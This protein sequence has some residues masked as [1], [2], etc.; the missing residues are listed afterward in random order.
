VATFSALGLQW[1]N[2]VTVSDA[3]LSQYPLGNPMFDVTADGLLVRG[4]GPAV[5]VLQ[6]GQLRHVTSPEAMSA[7]FFSFGSVSAYSDGVLDSLAEGPPLSGAPCPRF[8]PRDGTLL[9]GSGAAVYVV[10]G[11]IK[12]HVPNLLTFEVR[13]YRFENVDAVQ[14]AVLSLL[15]TGHPLVD[16]AVAGNLIGAS[17]RP[18]VYV[19]Q[20]GAKRHVAG[21][22]V[23]SACGYGFDSVNVISA[24]TVD[25]ITS[26]PALTGPPCPIVLFA[27]RSLLAGSGPAIYAIDANGQRRHIPNPEAFA[28]CGYLWGNVDVVADSTLQHVSEGPPLTSGTCP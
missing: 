9:R 15:A 1:Q 18:E 28:A 27:P 14:D 8:A 26:S 5:Y 13:R 4:S 11:G 21:L 6:G 25:G 3:I 12:R 2:L 22:E 10:Q 23:M 17:G 16:I 20:G 19:I 7:C 24:G